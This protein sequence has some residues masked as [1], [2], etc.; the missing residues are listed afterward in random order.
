M[1]DADETAMKIFRLCQIER[2]KKY[3]NERLSIS[4]KEKYDW[5]ENYLQ[6]Y[7]EIDFV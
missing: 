7:F 3:D 2:S 4:I 5:L 1:P 6:D